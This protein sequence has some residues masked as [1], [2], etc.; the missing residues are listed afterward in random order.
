MITRYWKPRQIAEL[1]N[2][3]QYDGCK[4]WRVSHGIYSERQDGFVR[5]RIK[6]ARF[7]AEYYVGHPARAGDNEERANAKE[8]TDGEGSNL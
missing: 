3:A 8:E 2:R 4:N 7:V 6:E 5:I 1:F